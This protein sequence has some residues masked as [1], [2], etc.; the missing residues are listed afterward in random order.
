MNAS[1]SLLV[2]SGVLRSNELLRGHWL[3]ARYRL[4]NGGQSMTKEFYEKM[5]PFYHLLY[6]DWEQSMERQATQLDRLIQENWGNEVRTILDVSCG[7]GTQ[8]LGLA[9]LNY[10]VTAS[11]LSKAEVERAKQEAQKRGLEIRFSVADMRQAYHHHQQQFGVVLSYDNA[12]PH[13]LSDADIRQAFGQFY[14][15][16]QPGGGVIISVRDYEKEERRTQIKPERVG[17]EAG[18][19]YVLLQVWEFE[20]EI[21]EMTMYVIKDD[22]SGACSAQV[23]RAK[24]YAVGATRLLVLL[25]EAGFEEVKRVDGIHSQPVL[26]GTRRR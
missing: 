17:V 7:I 26:V 10:Q 4:K 23:M 15:C 20:G 2:A 18:T 11:D 16:L 6:A 3:Q 1:L 25:E 24:Y 9:R 14:D 8:V 12:V 21:Y 13:L 22:R 19:R 5:T